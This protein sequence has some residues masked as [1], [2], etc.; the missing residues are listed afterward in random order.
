M[1]R[2]Y[3]LMVWMVFFLPDLCGQK[4]AFKA[5]AYEWIKKEMSKPNSAHFYPVLMERYRKADTTLTTVDFSVLYFGQVFTDT[6]SPYSRSEYVDSLSTLLSQ[7]SLQADD[8]RALIRYENLILDKYPFNLRDLNILSY[9]Y[10]KTGDTLSAMLTE[11]KLNRIIGTILSSGD[12][13]KEKSA[14]HVISVTHEYDILG[15][16]GFRFGGEQMLT[17]KGCDY[18]KVADNEYGIKGFY[19]DVNKILDKQSKLFRD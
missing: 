18:L 8:F 12:G 15:A 13:Q 3:L 17:E 7:D 5:P 2:Y 10:F 16:L 1:K 4:P 6:Y 11:Y 19:F 9:A 14:W